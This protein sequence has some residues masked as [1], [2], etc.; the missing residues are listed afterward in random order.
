MMFWIFFTHSQNWVPCLQGTFHHHFGTAIMF[1]QLHP[2][3]H[4]RKWAICIQQTAAFIQRNLGFTMQLIMV[5]MQLLRLM[6]IIRTWPIWLNM[7]ANLVSYVYLSNMA[8]IVQGECRIL[9]SIR[10]LFWF[11]VFISSFSLLCQHQITSW[12][13]STWIGKCIFKLFDAW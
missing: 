6:S 12:T 9:D 13:N 8:V 4:I 5:H 10:L 2:R 1:L 7:E 11:R 3:S